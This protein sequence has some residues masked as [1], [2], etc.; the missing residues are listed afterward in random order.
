MPIRFTARTAIVAVL[1]LLV[2]NVVT[3][4]VGSEDSSLTVA[5]KTEHYLH[6]IIDNTQFLYVAPDR[7]VTYTTNAKV[8]MLVEYFYAPG[9]GLSGSSIDTVE[10][11]YRSAQEGCSC[12]DGQTWGDCVY[13][14]PTG[15]TARLEIFPEDLEQ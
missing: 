6:I 14:P 2:I 15:G 3:I 1:T 13:N 7:A 12:S 5:N 11:P 8:S 10:V 4:A 9:Q